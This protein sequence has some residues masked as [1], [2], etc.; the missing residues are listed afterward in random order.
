MFTPTIEGIGLESALLYP[1]YYRQFGLRRAVQ[2]VAPTLIPLQKLE[3][4]RDSILHFVSDDESLT[5]IPQDDLILRNNPRLVMVHHNLE[6]VPVEGN[7]RSTHLPP[8]TMIKD[9]HRKFRNTRNLLNYESALRDS[10]TVVVENYGLLPHLYRYPV[11]YF[12]SYQKWINIQATLWTR[13]KQVSEFSNRQQYL[14]CKLPK[15]LPSLML[16]RK[17]EASFTRAVLAAFSEPEALFILEV[18]KWLGPNRASSQ[19][20]KAGTKALANMNLVWEESGVWTL[21]NLGMLDSWRQPTDDEIKAGADPKQGLITPDQM[22][23]R[24]LRMLMF[25]FETRTTPEDTDA[26]AETIATVT[27]KVVDPVGDQLVE[28][29]VAK[30]VGVKLTIPE[31]AETKAR[32]ITVRPGLNIDTLP[33]HPIEETPENAEAIDAAITKD[34]AALDHIQLKLDE[35]ELAKLDEAPAPKESAQPVIEYKPEERTLAS[36]IMSKVDLLADQGMLSGA[37]YRRFQAIS[38]AYEKLPNPYGEGTLA[39]QAVLDPAVLQIEQKN[40]IPNIDT[41]VDKSMLKSSLFEFDKRYIQEVL[42]KDVT[43]MV[44]GFQHAGVAIT[45]YEVQHIEDALNSSELHTV[46]LTPVQGKASTVHFRI[47]KVEADGTF[48]SNGVRYRMRK[49][50][51]DMP[52]RKVSP[53]KVALTSY[54]SKL[55]VNRSEKQVNNYAGWLTNQIAAMGMDTEN[56]KVTHLMLSNVFDSNNRT[57][58]IYSTMAQRFRSFQVGKY[59]FFFDYAARH[60]QFGEEAVKA[61]E[62]GGSVVVGRHGE[63][64]LVVDEHDNLYAVEGE[65][66]RLLG[67]TGQL[68]ELLGIQG[69]AP[70]EMIELK[71]FNKY[72]PV[73]M[74]LAHHMGLSNLLTL[75]KVTPRRVPAGE[76]AGVTDEEFSIRFEDETWVFNR[77]NRLAAQILA[78][79]ATFDK[80][81]RNY[82]AHLFDKKDIYFNVLEQS[83]IGVRYLRE[84]DL[85]VDLFVDPITEE[86]L[87]EM[88]EPTDFIG[89]LVR[90]SE[91]LLTDW[92][93]DETDMKYMRIKGY[94]RIAGAVYGELVKVLRLQRARGSATRAKIELPPYAVWQTI[95]QDP[96]VKLVEDCNP[97]HNLKEKEEITYSGV[98]GRSDR[99]MT[100]KTRVFHPNDMGVI[101]EATK[102]SAAVAITTFLTADPNFT[103]LRGTTGE[104]KEGQLGP[105]SLLSSSA[106]LAPAADRDDPKRVNFISIQQSA[107]TFARGYEPTPLRTGYEQIVAHRADDLYAYTA[108]GKGKVTAMSGKAVTITYED[109]SSKSVELGRRFGVAAGTTYPHEVVCPLKVGDEVNEGDIVSYNSH[110][111]QPDPLNPKQVLWKAGLLVKTAVME[112]VDTLEDS[113]AISERAAKLLETDITKVRDLIVPFDQTVHNLVQPGAEVDVES[114]LCTIE[115]AVTAQNNLFDIDSLDTLRLLAA[116]TPKA[117]FKGK[118]EKIEVFYHGELDDMS[119][120]LQELATESDRNRKRLSREMKTTYTSGQVD[121]SMRV[122]ARNLPFEHVVIRVYITGPMAAGV[123]D[124]GVFANQ[125]KT[126]FGRVMAGVNRTESGEDIDAIFGYQSISDRIVMSPEIIG[127]TNTLLKVMSKRVADVYRGK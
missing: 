9:Y 14:Q 126:I 121:D 63:T 19:L 106:L 2:L 39:E 72:V 125:M 67:A 51:G 109:G 123:G 28:K 107:G 60:A 33:E 49:Q 31:T 117:K 27:Q 8:S 29:T 99:S 45:G 5:G 62:K 54:Y 84:M 115:D 35:A 93:P 70:L 88:G 20:A 41:V 44:L 30:P 119:E 89:L 22:Q 36:G 110:Y 3:L 124:K 4:P 18:W 94:E 113:S 73:G 53:S 82:P 12:R 37:E 102:D 75:L 69:K 58:R 118:V 23:K 105:T 116:N 7:P 104:Y 55:Y 68:T 71:V 50:R 66:L 25:L 40:E 15:L 76:R 11:S 16:L 79:I 59:E 61:A 101:S 65:S 86:I 103:S 1:Q 108:K 111:F 48:R 85:M 32:T 87:K 92:S 17:A 42:P 26:V 114:I 24:F 47:P 90:A 6:L 74:F 97:I 57:P 77:E 56:E 91:M 83:G 46:Q 120:S 43:R 10:R 98:G 78:G 81:T 95:Q 64:L 127:T 34:L 112:S 80:S 122:D 21:M 13:V 96:A 100:G 52:I 38:T